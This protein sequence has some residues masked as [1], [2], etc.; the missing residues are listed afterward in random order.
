MTPLQRFTRDRSGFVFD[1]EIAPIGSVRPGETFVVETMDSLC[2]IVKS[3]ADV[4]TDLA[5]V[6]ERLGG[7]N[8]VTGPIYVEGCRAGDCI[9]V[10]VVAI[11]PA[12]RTRTGWTAV[13]PGWGGLTQ[14]MGYGIQDPL[15]PRTVMCPI[16]ERGKLRERGIEML[17]ST[18]QEALDA[19]DADPW[20]RTCSA[21]GLARSTWS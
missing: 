13:I 18:L 1:S 2:G 21:P 3:G 16:E 20:W 4:I 10:D 15:P 7:A 9:A 17:P 19:F 12:P 8:P 14:D 11:D 5:G 6:M